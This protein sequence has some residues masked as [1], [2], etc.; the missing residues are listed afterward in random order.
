MALLKQHPSAE[1]ATDR[2][3][4]QN[5][6]MP[7]FIAI[8]IIVRRKRNR[9]GEK[10]KDEGTAAEKRRGDAALVGECLR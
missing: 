5:M 6:C 4:Q 7:G 3:W 2:I 8:A 10:W 1:D 9:I